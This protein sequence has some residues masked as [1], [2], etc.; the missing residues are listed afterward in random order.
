[1]SNMSYC[2]YELTYADLE[3]CSEHILDKD[4]S[5]SE[6]RYRKLLV[7]LCRDIVLNVENNESE[8][9]EDESED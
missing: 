2:R 4:F 9:E 1:M 8:E 3:D 6:K 7:D 5:K